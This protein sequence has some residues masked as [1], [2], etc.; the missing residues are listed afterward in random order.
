MWGFYF[1]AAIVVWQGVMSLAGGLRFLAYVRRELEKPPVEFTPFVSLIAPCRG[2]DQGL[3]ENLA[4]LFL[5]DYPAYEIIFVTDRADD[6][7]VAVIEE[8]QREF[9]ARTHVASRI[10]VAGE[11]TES[12]QKVHNLR[13]AVAEAVPSRTLAKLIG[14]AARG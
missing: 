4:S 6:G 9:G 1:F 14:R 11:A 10:V 3:R 12:G 7:A 5:Q 2:L 8:V 13:A